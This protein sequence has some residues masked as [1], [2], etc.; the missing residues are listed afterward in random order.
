MAHCGKGE[1]CRGSALHIDTSLQLADKTDGG[2]TG[3]ITQSDKQQKAPAIKLWPEIHVDYKASVP[4][5]LVNLAACYL[6][7]DAESE[8][9][10]GMRLLSIAIRARDYD[11][12]DEYWDSLTK[13]MKGSLPSWAPNPGNEAS[14]AIEPLYSREGRTSKHAL[15]QLILSLRSRRMDKSYMSTPQG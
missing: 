2:G 13:T 6:F 7:Q 15:H 11:E 1:E 9:G 5:V 4:E 3:T 8:G 12:M 14:G 10:G